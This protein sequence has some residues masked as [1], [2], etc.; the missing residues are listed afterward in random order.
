MKLAEM[1]LLTSFL[2]CHQFR[3]EMLPTK[4][5]KKKKKIKFYYVMELHISAPPDAL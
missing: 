1:K 3:V 2:S 4:I 5:E